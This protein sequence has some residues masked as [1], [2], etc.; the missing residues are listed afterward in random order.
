MITHD[1][2]RKIAALAKLSLDGE[3]MAALADDIGGII[4]FADAVAGADIPELEAA[5]ADERYPLREDEPAGS[6]DRE[7]IL[8]NAARSRDGYFVAG[9]TGRRKS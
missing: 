3:D 7:D 1:E 6:Y 5:E 2:L 9:K 4:E 8:R